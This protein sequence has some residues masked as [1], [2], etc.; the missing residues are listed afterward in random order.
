VAALLSFW[1]EHDP[2]ALDEAS[3]EFGVG[4]AAAHAAAEALRYG[5][6]S[7]VSSS[8][9]GSFSSHGSLSAPSAPLSWRMRSPGS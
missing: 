7:A 1:S 2:E 8:Y 5:E 3:R 9:L 6:R 4:A